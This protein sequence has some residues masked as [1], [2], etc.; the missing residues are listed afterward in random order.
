MKNKHIYILLLILLI[1][2][3]IMYFSKKDSTI[4][5]ELRDFAVKDTSL[6]HKIFMTNKENNTVLLER[7]DFHWQ[8]NSQ[9]KARQDGINVLL[10]TIGRM[11]VKS[12]VSKSSQANI[13]TQLATNSTKVE[14]YD[15]HDKLIKVFY[16]GSA[17]SDNQ[18]TYMVLENSSVP[19]IMHLPGFF[20]YL[21]SRFF[22]DEHLWRCK[23]IVNYNYHD[24]ASVNITYPSNKNKSYTAYKDGPNQFR[25]IDANNNSI[26]NFDTIALKEYFGRF[27][28][29]NYESLLYDFPIFIKD[30]IFKSVPYAKIKIN[31]INNSSIELNTWIRPNIEENLKWDGTSYESDPD[32]MWSVLPND[33]HIITLQFFVLDPILKDPSFFLKK[34]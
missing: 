14:I 33:T 6:V 3:S 19:F 26:T 31:D 12:P 18:G 1:I 13:I 25:L 7:K 28:N 20:G 16:V 2:A 34:N 11:A 17:T 9:Y 8:V 29:I 4:R 21:S 32:R 10:R 15:K 27:R 23:E 22:I 24:I 5:R 30:S